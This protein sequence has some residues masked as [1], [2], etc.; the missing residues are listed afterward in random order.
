MAGGPLSEGKLEEG[1]LV[2]PWHG[3]RFD[4]E[5]GR[6]LDGPATRAAPCVETRVRT[7][8]IEVRKSSNRD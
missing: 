1:A 7:G 6:V 2:C 5:T 4:L 8:R 3:S